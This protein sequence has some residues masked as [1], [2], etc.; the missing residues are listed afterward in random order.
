[1]DDNL[2]DCFETDAANESRGAPKTY[3]DTLSYKAALALAKR[4]QEYWH[5]RDYPAAR[6]W[7]EPIGERFA[8]VGTYE[9]YRVV[10]NLVKGL[11][12][13]YRDERDPTGPT[14]DLPR[15]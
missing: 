13:R 6:F 5:K 10:S 8:K 9:L 3:P 1:M 11:P 7:V 15:R 14:K 4:L 12:P 2:V